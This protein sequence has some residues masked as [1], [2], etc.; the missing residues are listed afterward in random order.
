DVCREHGLEVDM[1]GFDKAMEQQR[2]RARGADAFAAD[3]SDRLAIDSESEFTGYEGVVLPSA[4]IVG[5]YKD[6]TA[7][8]QLAVGEEG[9]V[10]L[11]RTPFYAEAGGQTGDTGQLVANDAVF[12]VADTRQRQAAIVHMGKV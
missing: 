6:G 4:N 2:E 1:A 7:V 9:L 3:Y 12:A 10:V 11:D 8:Q 5:L